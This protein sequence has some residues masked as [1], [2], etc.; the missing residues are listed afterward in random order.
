MQE[1][2]L[3]YLREIAPFGETFDVE[4]DELVEV[5]MLAGSSGDPNQEGAW[6]DQDLS[7]LDEGLPPDDDLFKFTDDNNQFDKGPMPSNEVW[8]SH[9]MCIESHLSHA[10]ESPPPHCSLYSMHMAQHSLRSIGFTCWKNMF[11]Y[12]AAHTT[13]L[14]LFYLTIHRE[15]YDAFA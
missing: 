2:L 13:A 5:L 10:P 14:L 9:V 7:F 6:N 8:C 15:H 11:D 4:Q 3:R 1:D 12:E